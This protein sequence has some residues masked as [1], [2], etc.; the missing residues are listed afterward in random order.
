MQHKFKTSN[1][2]TM[3]LLKYAICDSKK[4][5]CIKK[6]KGNGLLSGL[7]IRTTLSIIPLL[8]NILF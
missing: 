5:R 3:L 4:S 8:G 7:G 2:K 6:Q 1:G